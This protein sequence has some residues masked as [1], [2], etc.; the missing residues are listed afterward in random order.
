MRH[1]K[2]SNTEELVA[3]GFLEPDELSELIECRDY[4][5]QLRFALHMLTGRDE[6][7]LLF[8]HQK[9]VAKMMGFENNENQLAVEQMM[10][11]FYCSVRRVMEL[12]EM[13][14][15][16][17]Y[18]ATLG[19]VSK[20]PIKRINND[21]QRR[22]SYIDALPHVDLNLPQ[23]IMLLL[24]TALNY[25]SVKGIYATTLRRMREGLN[26]LN[27]PLVDFVDC[28]Q[29][30]LAILKHERGI[31]ALSFMHKHGVLSSYLPE[32]QQ[33][34]GQMQF[35]LFHAYTVDEHTHRLLKNINRFFIPEHEDELPLASKISGH[36]PKRGLLVLAAIFHDIGKGRG[37]DHSKLGAV[38]ALRFCKHHNM[39]D[40]DGRLVSWLVENHLLMSMIAQRRDISDPDVIFDFAEKV[41]DN[42][43]LNY[44][45]CLTVADIRATNDNLWNGW[46]DSLLKELYFAT[47]RTLSRGQ[48]QT[49]DIRAR[50]REHQAKARKSLT[51]NNIDSVQADELWQSLPADYFLRHTPEQVTWHTQSILQHESEDPLVL[52][53]KKATRGGTEVFVHCPNRPKLF[54]TVM[55]VLDNK[56]LTV[57]DA[58]ILTTKTNYA[59]D[60]FIILEQN[61]KTV[62]GASRVQ[63]IQK[64]LVK[65]IKAEDDKLPNFKKISR[66]MRPFQVDTQVSFL[67]SKRNATTMMELVA[68]D[69]P[70]LLAKVGDIFYQCNITL[71]GAKITTIG[72]RA[73]DFFRIQTIDG[74]ELN[75]DQK[76]LLKETLVSRLNSKS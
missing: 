35:D 29:L 49:T 17:F 21:Y 36:L 23:N 63:S 54:A 62:S 15:Q 39:N 76:Q 46:K 32:W 28:R 22:G 73:E 8:D 48:E 59:M 20:L 55:A 43:R 61:G 53:S 5:W 64:A 68:L 71:V 25:P 67:P 40:H 58:S 75:E 10:K 52:V 41:R 13:L 50:V 11:R 45:Y 30:F 2:A 7:R 38:D 42:D 44:L 16:L 34:E 51:D 66:K 26:A 4:L 1:F 31:A 65:S 74:N 3:R 14:L 6:N 57:H 47:Q 37:G 9:D 69:T 70:G 27:R 72:E 56:N 12:N 18:Q 33:I 24:V 60:T 19:H